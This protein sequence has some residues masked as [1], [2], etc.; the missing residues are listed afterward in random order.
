M[1]THIESKNWSDVKEICKESMNHFVALLD[2]K[3][4]FQHDS[5]LPAFLRVYTPGS[6]Y[7]S[8]C[9]LGVDG[10]Q[11]CKEYRESNQVISTL[12]RHDNVYMCH[13]RGRWYERFIIN[14]KHLKV[15]P[16]KIKKYIQSALQEKHILETH[17][18]I[19]SERLKKTHE[20]HVKALERSRKKQKLEKDPEE[21]IDNDLSEIFALKH[22]I[23]IM[24]IEGE[25]MYAE[26]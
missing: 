6:V 4:S 18:L 7:A 24:K 25:K 14:M 17:K 8:T 1:F 23:P 26:K 20:E 16:V 19:L 11:K 2:S 3:E 13:Y 22:E 15:S 5:S 21:S 12:L 10:Y 9:W